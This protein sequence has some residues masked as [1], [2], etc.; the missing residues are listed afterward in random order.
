VFS[1]N[2][3]LEPNKTISMKRSKFTEEQ[4]AFAIRKAEIGT[5]FEEICRQM[6]IIK[7]D[8]PTIKQKNIDI[9]EKL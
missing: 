2:E 8:L 6:G 5:R 7:S 1:G 9:C 4:V 3:Y